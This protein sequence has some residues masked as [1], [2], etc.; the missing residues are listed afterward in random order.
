MDV[1]K[2][3]LRHALAVF[4]LDP[5]SNVHGVPHWVRVWNNARRL[6]EHVPGVGP[7]D[8]DVLAW[9]AFLHDC[10]RE[11]DDADPRHGMRASEYAKRLWEIG[12]IGLEP[13]RMWLLKTALEGHSAGYFIEDPVVLVCWDADRLDLPRVHVQPDPRRMCTRAGAIMARAL[14]RLQ[15]RN[16][17]RGRVFAPQLNKGRIAA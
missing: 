4:A 8:V 15:P 9:F 16:S 10:K 17:Q 12:A 5:S 1:V 3:A 6:A 11:N 13:D 14:P 7:S 2:H